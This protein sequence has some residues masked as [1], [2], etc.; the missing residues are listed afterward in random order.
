[1]VGPQG[2]FHSTLLICEDPVQLAELCSYLVPRIWT[3]HPIRPVRRATTFKQFCQKLFKDTQISSGCILLAL[4]Y[5][6]QLR[7]AYAILPGT[8]GS[9]IRIFTTALILANKY[10]DDNT[11]TNKT[12]SEVSGIPTHELNIMEMEYLSALDYQIHVHCI[13]FCSWVTQC[14]KWL[15][16]FK[17]PSSVSSTGLSVKRSQSHQDTSRNNKKKRIIL[18]CPRQQ[19]VSSSFTFHSLPAAA[20]PMSQPPFHQKQQQQQQQQHHQSLPHMSNK[21]SF[22]P[23]MTSSTSTS[24]MAQLLPPTHLLPLPLT[25]STSAHHHHHYHQPAPSFASV[26][27]SSSA[28]CASHASPLAPALPHTTTLPPPPAFMSWDSTMLPLLPTSGATA[29]ASAAAFA[30]YQQRQYPYHHHPAVLVNHIRCLE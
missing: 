8:I 10:L 16:Q 7:I 2:L 13:R 24:S 9:E 27:Y 20:T 30:T 12:W 18:P 3:G 17:T 5:L 4:Y 21:A 25:S 23:N 22:A 6:Q 14:Q 29:A 11:F 28:S 1:M 19:A 26:S 15:H